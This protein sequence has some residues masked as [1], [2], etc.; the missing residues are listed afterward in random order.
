MK[1]ISVDEKLPDFETGV[2]VATVEGKITAAQLFEHRLP[3]DFKP[4]PGSGWDSYMIKR[5]QRGWGW[6]PYLVSSS[7]WEW[8]EFDDEDVTHWCPL[9]EPPK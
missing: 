7:E 9:P 3:D 6:H 5:A 1:W 2:L 8:L 4:G